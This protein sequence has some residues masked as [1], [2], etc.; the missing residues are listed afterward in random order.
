[1]ARTLILAESGFGKSSMI[2]PNPKIGVEGLD[3][4]DTYVISATT[5]PLPF[6]NSLNVYPVTTYEGLIAGDTKSRK[7][8]TNQ[9]PIIA[10]IIL[11]LIPTPIVHI[12]IDDANYIMQD[13]YMKDA[14]KS[15][16]DAP[17]KIGYQ[18]GLLFDAIEQA[19]AAGKEIYMLAHYE[20]FKKK[21]DNSI[22]Y[23]MKTTG[24]MVSEFITPEGK[25]DN[26]F[27]GDEEYDDRTKVVKRFLVTNK[28]GTWPAKSA[29]GMF[30]LH[31]PNDLGYISKKIYNY[32]N[33]IEEEVDH[34]FFGKAIN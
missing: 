9:A 34:P 32:Y 31:I 6:G 13:Q 33:G 2:G 30:P 29:P 12:V 1:M 4:K 14:L 23:R 3:P 11:A 21:N 26:V 22:S 24:N 20:T 5:R 18:M 7:I 8:N 27:F 16:W 10:K 15:G 17:K 19:A 25:F 28:D